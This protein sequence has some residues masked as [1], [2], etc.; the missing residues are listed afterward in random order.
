[1][2]VQRI[3]GALMLRLAGKRDKNLDLIRAWEWKGV[4]EVFV[5][6]IIEEGV[7]V[8]GSRGR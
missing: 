2:E 4:E 1:V 6:E 3:L 8:E 5:V 7:V